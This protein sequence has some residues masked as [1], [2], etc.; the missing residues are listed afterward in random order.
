[1][2]ALV[3]G[4]VMLD[5]FLYG[6]SS[7]LSPEAPVPVVLIDHEMSVLGGA[8][9]VAA[10]LRSLGAQVDICGFV[11]DNDRHVELLQLF[12]EID[13]PT[14][15][16]VSC[17]DAHTI[18]K[19]RVISQ[20]QHLLRFDKECLK[21]YNNYAGL[22]NKLKLLAKNDY[23]FVIISDYNK[24]V[25]NNETMSLTKKYFSHVPIFVDPRPKN[26]NSYSDT[27][28]ITPN[29]SE[30][31]SILND[32]ESSMEDLACNIKQKLN[33][34]IVIITLSDK[35]I[36]LLDEHNRKYH[37][38]AYQFQTKERLHRLD[39]SG[40]GDTLIG[41]FAACLA[42]KFTTVES[43]IIANMS[44]AIVVNKLGTAVCQIDELKKEFVNVIDILKEVQDV[45]KMVT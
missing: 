41:T 14:D 17:E 38:D 22:E 7:R 11:G 34:A 44:A 9:N 32:Y 35:G 6:K 43:A 10:N 23:D 18:T 13:L 30:A 5:V 3:I 27:F 12:N 19:T 1:M 42:N 33:V 16:L 26:Y 31:Q 36:F 40:A 45:K 29:L 24:G 39:V 28:C 15:N 25:I 8:A 2:F 20:G 4:D 21:D 37:I